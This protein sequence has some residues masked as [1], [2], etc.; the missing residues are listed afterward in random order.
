M[1][2]KSFLTENYDI[3]D[4]VEI[5]MGRN[6]GESGK[7]A[8]PDTEN[9]DLKRN[10]YWVV[11]DNGED[12][13]LRKDWIKL[14]ESMKNAMNER[15]KKLKSPVELGG[16]RKG[17]YYLHS[18]GMDVNGNWS[19]KVSRGSHPPKKVQHQPN[20]GEKIR[21]D[22]SEREIQ[23]SQ[24]A[25]QIIDYYERF[26][27]EAARMRLKDIMKEIL[28]EDS[29][30]Q[31]LV[32][33]VMDIIGIDSPQDLDDDQRAK[34][35]SYLNTIWNP[36]TGEKRKE[37]DEEAISAIM[38][39]E[40]V[41]EN[42]KEY[43]SDIEDYGHQFRRR[44]EKDHRKLRIGDWEFYVDDMAGTFIWHS[45]DITD[46]DTIQVLATPFWEGMEAIP[47]NIIEPDGSEG[48]ELD[49]KF[50]PSFDYKKDAKRYIKEMEKLFKNLKL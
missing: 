11:L 14:E 4:R 41:E 33:Q 16:G 26:V 5:V 1:K 38:G 50:R 36:E 40:K 47:I 28:E 24:T 22:D 49:I 37:P 19:Y 35:F 34:F 48:M 18:V 15:M 29:K 30:Y 10:E 12:L 2:L 25:A 7:I 9:I 20:W 13:V 17:H 8:D 27:K 46:D 6:K 39:D 32:R 21:R 42:L 23:R 45:G 3:G 43:E 44:F 31:Q